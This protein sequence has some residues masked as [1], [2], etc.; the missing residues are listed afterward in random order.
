MKSRIER[1]TC[2]AEMSPKDCSGLVEICCS[3]YGR[4]YDNTQASGGRGGTVSSVSAHTLARRS[5]PRVLSDGRETSRRS[6][7]G[8]E[9]GCAAQP[10]QAF[11][12][13]TMLSRAAVFM[14]SARDLG[15]ASSM[16]GG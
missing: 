15:W 14:G 6:R 3:Y 7:A 8:R 4:S 5:G 2:R 1:H 9:A 13:P 11:S 10:G 16:A 12:T